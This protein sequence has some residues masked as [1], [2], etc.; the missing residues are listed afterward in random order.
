MRDPGIEAYRRQQLESM[1]PERLV[2]VAF[3]QGMLACRRREKARAQRTVIEL[4][5]GLD[6]EYEDQAG[7]LLKLYDWILQLLGEDRFAEAEQ[8]FDRL[9][10]AWGQA[11]T[12]IGVA[13]PGG[14]QVAVT[15]TPASEPQRGAR[16]D[17]TG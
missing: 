1:T 9:R 11:L 17:L 14:S 12:G 3:E 7:G 13:R 2:L 16:A 10:Q 8:V 15:G 6:F 4:I 5:G